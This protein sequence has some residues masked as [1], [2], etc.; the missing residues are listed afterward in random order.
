[1]VEIPAGWF[2]MGWE[3]GPS[4]RAA[5]PPR[6]AG[7]LRHRPLPGDQSRVR[8]LPRGTAAP[9]PPP[10]WTHP[11]F[12]DARATRGRRRAGPRPS[13]TATGS[14]ASRAGPSASPPRRSGRR[15]RAAASRTRAFPGATPIPARARFDAP[16]ARHREQAEPAR[17]AR[18][19]R[20]LPR[21]VPG[22][23]DAGLLRGLAGAKSAG[24]GDGTRRISRGGAWRHQDPWSPVAH[25]SSLP[26]ALRYSDYGFRVVRA[27][28][29]PR[30]T[31]RSAASAR[32][33]Q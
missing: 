24:P 12:G 31:S 21:V 26:P 23:G 8:A 29:P 5:A 18:A 33:S 3:R 14:P 19:L 32:V 27:P 1:M 25:R 22:L 15:P 28:D 10:W 30:Y 17:P 9:P 2:W 7:C 6:L 13:R 11:R 20:R 16:A 4:R